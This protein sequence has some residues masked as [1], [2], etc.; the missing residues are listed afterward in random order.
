MQSLI[1]VDGKEIKKAKG[2]NKHVAKNT[3]IKNILM[4]C[5]IKK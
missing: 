1:D 3:G 5:L 4:F 2:F